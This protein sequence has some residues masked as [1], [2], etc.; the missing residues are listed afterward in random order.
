M[1]YAVCQG[2]GLDEIPSEG[3]AE[4]SQSIEEEVRCSYSKIQITSETYC[5]G[6]SSSSSIQS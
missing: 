4:G 2:T 1:L 5:R 3:G 6:R